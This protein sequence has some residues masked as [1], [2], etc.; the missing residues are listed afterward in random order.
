VVKVSAGPV[1]AGA[2]WWAALPPAEAEVTCG[3]QTHR[4]LWEAGRLTASD[5]P[6]AEGELVLA[7]LGG[8]RSECIDLVES[9]GSRGDD[10]E[11]L[12][13]G[14]RSADDE[15]TITADEVAE[16]R[17]G[18][19]WVAYAPLAMRHRGAAALRPR[20][21]PRRLVSYGGS[22]PVAAR[23]RAVMAHRARGSAVFSSSA[24]HGMF[25]LGSGG[26]RPTRHSSHRPH[27]EAGRAA[28][29]RAELFSLLALGAEFQFRL[30][31]TVAAAWADGGSRAGE[32]A[33]GRPALVAALS[34]RLA[35]AAQ[36]WLGIDPGQVEVDL[37]EGAGWGRLEMSD[38]GGLRGA[39][40][41]AWLASV[42]AAGLAVTGGHLIVEVKEVAWP[43]ATVLGVPGPG[44]DPVILRVRA[45]DGG[46]W[47]AATPQARK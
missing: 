44:A 3:A 35:P 36:S 16:M 6:D 18:G 14:P 13:V 42:W 39:L 2:P 43:E 32:R 24:S 12:A 1:Q 17:G 23:R 4:L 21:L 41:A 11:V 9:W 34:G 46:R 27:D 40:S 38:G 5:H 25:S 33:A 20:R 45:A 8:E 30:S 15:L 37:H 19:G 7:A 28:T 22:G 26:L 29:R 10:L 47:S 31:A